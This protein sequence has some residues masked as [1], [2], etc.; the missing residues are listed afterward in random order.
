MSSERE[1]IIRNSKCIKKLCDRIDNVGWV[2]ETA[3]GATGPYIDRLEVSNGETVL[4]TFL[5]CA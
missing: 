4:L 3:T 2:F 1:T 5:L